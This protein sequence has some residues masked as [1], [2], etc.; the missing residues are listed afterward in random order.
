MST[1][2]PYDAYLRHLDADGQR[3]R[4][5]A[6][7]HLD[8]DVP[9]CPGWTVTDL[10]DHVGEVYLH[11]VHCLRHGRPSAWPAERPE[12]PPLDKLE[13]AHSALLAELRARDETTEA[14]TW[15]PAEQTAGFWARRMAQESV[16]H[17]IDAEQAADDVTSI[18]ASLALDGVDEVLTRF[19]GDPGLGWPVAEIPPAT[20]VL[21]TRDRSWT[22]CLESDSVAVEPG[23]VGDKADATDAVVAG[24]PVDLLLW[25]WGRGPIDALRTDGS[26]ATLTLLS[27]RMAVATQ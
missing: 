6:A 25:L 10:V 2:L 1:R 17:R 22:V 21:Q 16:V 3:L 23:T 15:W 12:Q 7:P 18:D 14:Y 24:D 26:A 27:E 5:I 8:A 19:L 20:V 13:S 11:K 4:E 9:S